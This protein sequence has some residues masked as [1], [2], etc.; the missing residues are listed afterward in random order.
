MSKLDKFL[1]LLKSRDV[2]DLRQIIT[3]RK[4]SLGHGN[5]F[6]GVVCPLGDRFCLRGG[7]GL[8]PGGSASGVRGACI[9]VGLPTGL[10]VGKTPRN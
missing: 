1:N 8:H 4:R 9:L 6:T 3:A 10:G 7:V 5:V 2:V